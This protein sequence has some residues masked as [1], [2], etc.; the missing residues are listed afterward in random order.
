MNFKLELVITYHSVPDGGKR[1]FS[2]FICFVCMMSVFFGLKTV[3]L[4]NGYNIVIFFTVT[5]QLLKVTKKNEE[6]HARS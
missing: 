3:K 5:K 6:N 4:I 2:N 1:T